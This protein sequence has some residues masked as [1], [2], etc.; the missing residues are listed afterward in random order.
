MRRAT[1]EMLR[2]PRCFGG[3]LVPE[4]PVDQPR[5][6]F[7]P[8]RCLGCTATYPVGEGLI[9][10]VLE[11]P[12]PA[13][14]QRAMEHPLTARSYE[15]YIR[16]AFELALTAGRFDR[17]REYTAYRAMLGKVNG[18]LVELGCGT[19]W[20]ARRL[21]AEPQA[22]R[23]IGLDVSK[24]MI[25][26]AIAQAREHS[27]AIDFVR[28]LVPPLP[29][30]DASVGAVLQPR[31]VHAFVDLPS[32]LKEVARVLKPQGRYVASTWPPPAL[33]RP[34]YRAAGLFERSAAQL[35]AA[36]EDVGLVGFELLR[37]SRVLVFKAER[38]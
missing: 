12:P 2:C 15:R 26:E 9:D 35:R 4:S 7:G 14:L 27:V 30:Q 6:H 21:G 24:P 36:C 18:S 11:R 31:S 38:P 1:L 10:F 37:E 32:L 23:I 13:G 20:F 33:T 25:E 5:M 22:P 3:S 28:A 17:E 34:L 8:V 19:G 29:F 16:P